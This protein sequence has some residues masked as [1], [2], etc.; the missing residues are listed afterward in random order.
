P[1]APAA[2]GVRA[3]APTASGAGAHPAVPPARTSSG[4]HAA[5]AA[6]RGAHAAVPAPHPET[7][8]APA[9]AAAP[10][11]VA[12]AEAAPAVTRTVPGGWGVAVP[13][14]TT[15]AAA[16]VRHVGS[17]RQNHRQHHA[18]HLSAPPRTEGQAAALIATA[19]ERR[20]VLLGES[21]TGSRTVK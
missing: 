12:V 18:V 6:G 4:A 1:V 7:G 16:E 21:R 14:T 5:G 17:S 19:V 11:R 15:M 3:A 9:V 10:D 20:R 13:A 2:R 8:A